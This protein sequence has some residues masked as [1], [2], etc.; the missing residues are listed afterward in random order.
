[1][2]VSD[3][4]QNTPT[5]NH[6]QNQKNFDYPSW[7]QSRGTGAPVAHLADV[8]VDILYLIRPGTPQGIKHVGFWDDYFS[9]QGAQVERV[10]R[11]PR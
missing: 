6:Y 4:L 8:K 1:M 2:I 9:G 7:Y 11:I 3:M 10:Q 5:L